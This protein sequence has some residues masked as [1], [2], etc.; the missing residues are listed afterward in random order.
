MEEKEEGK[1]KDGV[2]IVTSPEILVSF[3]NSIAHDTL[4]DLGDH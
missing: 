4:N 3:H 1:E 2:L